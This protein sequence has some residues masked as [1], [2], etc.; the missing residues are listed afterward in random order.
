MSDSP[1][2][3]QQSPLPPEKVTKA[4]RNPVSIK[5]RIIQRACVALI[6]SFGVLLSYYMG[7]LDAV[8]D[9]SIRQKVNW[10]DDTK[11]VE[12]LRNRTINDKIVTTRPSCLV[13]IVNGNAPPEVTDV[14]VREKHNKECSDTSNDFPLLFTFRVNRVNGTIQIDRNSSNHFYPFQ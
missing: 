11:M 5:R 8:I 6:L 13:F 7:W 2:S 3:K 14:Q 1:S 10:F 4:R 12:Y 9:Q